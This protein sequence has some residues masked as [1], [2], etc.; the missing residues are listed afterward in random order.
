MAP[1]LH[2]YAMNWVSYKQTDTSSLQ[3]NLQ[4]C[5]ANY[6]KAERKDGGGANSQ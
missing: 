2:Y 5:L 3:V 4:V 1:N 6:N